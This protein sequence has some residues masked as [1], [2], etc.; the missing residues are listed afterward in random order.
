MRII[1][2]ELSNVMAIGAFHPSGAVRPSCFCKFAI[3]SSV[4][5]PVLCPSGC[6][7]FGEFNGSENERKEGK[8]PVGYGQLKA[9]KG[10]QR[11]LG[12]TKGKEW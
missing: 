3:E 9:Q 5:L 8:G 11:A 7:H 6:Q 10:I 12:Q 2:R 4:F 1:E